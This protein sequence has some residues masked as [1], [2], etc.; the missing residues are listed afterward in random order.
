M[1]LKEKALDI[2]EIVQPEAAP[3]IEIAKAA[4]R[5]KKA[6]GVCDRD[7]RSSYRGSSGEDRLH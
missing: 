5:R 3:A 6:R 2:A 1:A 7:R 4:E